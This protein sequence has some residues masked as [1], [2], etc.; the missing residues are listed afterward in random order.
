MTDRYMALTVVLEKE[1]REDDAESL[2][3]AIG[4][5]RG[6]AKVIPEVS[7]IGVSV[8]RITAKNEIYQELFKVLNNV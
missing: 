2:I 7:D 4:M 1:I 5:I 3:I 8:A 6:V